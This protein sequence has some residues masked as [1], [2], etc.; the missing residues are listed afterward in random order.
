MLLWLAFVFGR[1]LRAGA[2][3]LIEQ[4]AR[5]GTPAMPMALR[6]YTR[7]LTA[8]WCGYFVVAAVVTAASALAAA[9]EM[10]GG[11]AG[12][13]GFAGV[14]LAVWACTALLFIGERIVRPFIFPGHVFPS[15]WQQLLDTC[16]IWRPRSDG[17]GQTRP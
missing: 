6:C 1:T 7:R 3:P 13:A 15:L 8:V 2:T 14:S 9:G 17:G 16:S 5:R 12:L 11:T 10:A 4:V